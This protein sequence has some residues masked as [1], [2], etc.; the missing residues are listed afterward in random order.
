[1]A[2]VKKEENTEEQFQGAVDNILD[3]YN[4]A[5]DKEIEVPMTEIPKRAP[6]V[7]GYAVQHEAS[8]NPQELVNCLRNERVIARFI[9]KP[10]MI[11]NPSHVLYGGMSESSTRSFVVPRLSSTGLFVNVLTNSEKAF[12]EHV[13]GLEKDALSIYR[14]QNNFW[15]D[16]NPDGI[17]KVVLHK[18]DT[19]FDLSVPEDYIK[20]KVLLANKNLIASSLQELEDH[21]KATYQY[22]LISESSNSKNNL[23]KMDATMECYMEFGRVRD[24]ADT[25]RTIIEIL[26]RRPLSARIKPDYLQGKISEYIQKDPRRF[27]GIIKDELLPLKVLVKRGVNAGLIGTMGNTYYLKDGNVQ[28]H[29]LGEEGTLNNAAKYLGSVKHQEVKYMLEAK[30]N[31]Q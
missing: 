28:L 24:D 11:T 14:K 21:P 6:V 30:L 17:G 29:E 12:L 25:L 13:M 3:G 2:R 7:S 31:E 10:G 5:L 9:E 19:Y 18:Q 16:A 27:L 8:H 23:S 20:Y 26:E 4:V 15:S 22:V 1:M